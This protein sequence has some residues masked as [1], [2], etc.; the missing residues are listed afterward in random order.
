MYSVFSTVNIISQSQ[1]DEEVK[2]PTFLLPDTK[3]RRTYLQALTQSSNADKADTNDSTV[4]RSSESSTVEWQHKI[5]SAEAEAKR[6]K[7]AWERNE[8]AV[9][10]AQLKFKVGA[11]V[12]TT[13]PAVAP[14]PKRKKAKGKRRRRNRVYGKVVHHSIYQPRF[15]KVKFNNGKEFYCTHEV[16]TFVSNEAPNNGLGADSNGKLTTKP[17]DYRF[18]NK[19]AIMTSILE[20]KIA[21]EYDSIEDGTFDTVTK[22]FKGQYN[23]LSARKISK[24]YNLCKHTLYNV[25]PISW[26]GKIELS[27]NKKMYHGTNHSSKTHSVTSPDLNKEL[28][29][30]K[31]VSECVSVKKSSMDTNE[32]EEISLPEEIKKRR[33]ERR[34]KL[35]EYDSSDSDSSNDNNNSNVI[36]TIK[37]FK[38]IADEYK[39]KSGKSFIVLISSSNYKY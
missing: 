14:L 6:Q 17:F 30:V 29:S 28:H 11:H 8:A 18:I 22:A 15:W 31:N 1:H 25:S 27:I 21:P 10:E 9:L 7:D 2:N 33:V 19:E 32:I 20:S 38:I 23:W 5:T 26:A 13:N 39:S 34:M 3:P 35:K 4:A 36:D 37:D 16:V 12:Y 24:H